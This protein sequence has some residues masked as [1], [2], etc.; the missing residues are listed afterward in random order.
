MEGYTIEEVD[1]M[2][3]EA[4]TAAR[5]AYARNYHKDVVGGSAEKEV[6]RIK[7]LRDLVRCGFSV[8]DFGSGLV[9]LNDK[10]VFSLLTRKWRN[11]NSNKWYLCKMDLST[12]KKAAGLT[13]D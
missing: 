12:I 9:I 4:L 5:E 7:T 10:F 6:S 8:K 1:A 13:D 2:L 3:S 11:V